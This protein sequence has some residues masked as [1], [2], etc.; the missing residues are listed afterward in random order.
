MCTLQYSVYTLNG[1]K[2]NGKIYV[3][4]NIFIER[5]GIWAIHTHSGTLAHPDTFSSV[6]TFHPVWYLWIK[7]RVDVE[8][9]PIDHLPTVFNIILA[10]CLPIHYGMLYI[11]H[12]VPAI[13]FSRMLHLTLTHLHNNTQMLNRPSLQRHRL[14]HLG[15]CVDPCVSL[16]RANSQRKKINASINTLWSFVWSTFVT[17][18]N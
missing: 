18:F 4:V 1:G 9:T 16:L 7:V 3:A 15:N 5:L 14:R 2:P 11:S 12:G 6:Q 17:L 8:G 13:A 10:Q